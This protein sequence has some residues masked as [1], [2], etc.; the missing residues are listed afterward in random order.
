MPLSCFSN[1]SK[2]VILYGDLIFTTVE[3]W[4]FYA[5]WSVCLTCRIEVFA[6]LGGSKVRL[7]YV[8]DNFVLKSAAAIIGGRL[9]FFCQNTAV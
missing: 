8:Y 6:N 9:R 7:M 2:S 1:L 4:V 5:R 3:N